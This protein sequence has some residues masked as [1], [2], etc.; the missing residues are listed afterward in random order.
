M[1]HLRFALTLLVLFLTGCPSAADE[2]TIVDVCTKSAVQCRIGGGKLG[3]CMMKV[4]GSFEC[5]S[6]H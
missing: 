1:V 3:V 6:Q 5:A 4:D 2:A